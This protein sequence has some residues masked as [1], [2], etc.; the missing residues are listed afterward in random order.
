MHRI[1]MDETKVIQVV[2]D[3]VCPWCYIGK[4]RLQAALHLLDRTDLE[5]RWSPFQLNPNAPPEGWNR[6][7]YRVA[8]F[9]S[10]EVS[11]T[12]E[13]RVKDAGAEEGIHFRFDQIEKTPN[14]FD[15][16]RLIWLAGREGKQDETVENLFRAYFIEAR[17]VGDPSVLCDIGVESGIPA[18]SLDALFSTSLGTAEVARAEEDARAQGVSG[19]PTFFV[20][21]EPVT[22]GAHPPQLLAAM[23]SPYLDSAV[24][25]ARPKSM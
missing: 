3:V 2:S 17:S 11:S 9:G 4:R 24:D 15:A 18:A 13:S 19:V 8:K 20:N 22:S 10:L 5:I 23:L 25:H 14:T 21:G 1:G 16:H 7:E 6:R 12:L